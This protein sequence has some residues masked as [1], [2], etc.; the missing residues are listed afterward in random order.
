MKIVDQ[1]YQCNVPGENSATW[2]I[3]CH[4]RI[5][6][7]HSGQQIVIMSDLGCETSWFIPYKLEQLATQIVKEFQLNPDRLVWIE[8]DLFYAGRSSGTKF[9]QVL[10]Q[11]K[12]GK[13][14]NPQWYS[15]SD[16]WGAASIGEM[17]HLATA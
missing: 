6:Q 1:A 12:A 16:E 9:S 2:T 5:F 17:L 8:H 15:L 11:W 4:L 13:A 3:R 14:I 10:F 7:Q